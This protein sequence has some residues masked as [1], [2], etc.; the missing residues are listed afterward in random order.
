VSVTRII[1][2]DPGI[3]GALALLHNQSVVHLADM[4]IIDGQVD[5]YT[6]TAL[7]ADWGAVDRV[8]VEV[9]QAMPRQGVSSTFRTGAN[10][11]RILGVLAAL[12]RPVTHVRASVWTQ[13]LRVGPDKNAHRRRCQ[14][15]WPYIAGQYARVKD[16]GRADA[17]LIALWAASG[18]LA[19]AA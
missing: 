13:A 15:E 14:D 9:Q 7:L 19:G 4:P 1:G 3:T 18:L 8:V 16:D 6:L 17:C 10:Y 2:C 12:E 11:G 5:C